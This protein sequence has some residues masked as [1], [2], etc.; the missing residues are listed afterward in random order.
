MATTP[1][2]PAPSA[3]PLRRIGLLPLWLRAT[4]LI[5]A[6]ISASVWFTGE[7]TRRLDEEHRL[8]EMRAGVQRAAGLLAGLVSEALV[9][10]DRAT[11]DAI[12]KQYVSAW[13]QVTFVHVADAQGRFF[14]EWQQ[15]PIR[16]GDGILKFE[17]PVLFGRQ[18]FG[19]LSLYVDLNG[20]LASIRV[21]AVAAQRRAALTLLALA[22]LIV[23]LVG[24]A[25]MEPVRELGDRAAAL[26]ARHGAA[27]AADMDEVGRLRA[28]LDLLERLPGRK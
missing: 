1:P 3:G 7:A 12:V 22:L 16:F 11:A 5:L 17:E 10:G 24:Y 26:L 15:R 6:G 8:S 4:A 21:H 14:T 13:P 18:H 27:G 19:T 20:T 2:E 9:T 28:A 25:A 23:A